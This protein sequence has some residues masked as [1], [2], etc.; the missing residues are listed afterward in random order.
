MVVLWY[1]T[2]SQYSNIL[3]RLSYVRKGRSPGWFRAH[4]S[5]SYWEESPS[6]K[7]VQNVGISQGKV[8][9]VKKCVTFV[10]NIWRHTLSLKNSPMIGT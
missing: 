10:A 3:Q 4:K 1:V 8:F 2:L 9:S 7:Q 5:C 6:L